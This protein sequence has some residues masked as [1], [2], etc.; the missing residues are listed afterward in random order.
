M[1]SFD[2]LAY[3]DS[4]REA[5]EEANARLTREDK[6]CEPGCVISL[7]RGYPLVCTP[8]TTERAELATSIKKSDD[9]IVAVGIGWRC[10]IRMVTRKP[11]SSACCLV[12]TRL[13]ASNASDVSDN[14]VVRCWPPMS[15]SCSS[16]SP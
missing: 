7:D 12:A 13:R 10:I 6:P 3:R 1:M 4:M 14:R 16:A 8:R 11:S 2:R 15:T 5:F 9:S